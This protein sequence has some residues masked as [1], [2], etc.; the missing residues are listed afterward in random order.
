[1][2]QDRAVALGTLRP[3]EPTQDQLEGCQVI[4]MLQKASFA[5]EMGW[6]TDPLQE[7]MGK[8][9]DPG[10]DKPA[11]NSSKTGEAGN[12]PQRMRRT[13][14]LTQKAVSLGSKVTAASHQPPFP[15]F[16]TIISP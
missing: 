16:L 8:T 6:R 14:G 3:Q 7:D 9:V 12:P 15:T 2:K 13:L 4:N 1:M 10:Q 11:L 5:R